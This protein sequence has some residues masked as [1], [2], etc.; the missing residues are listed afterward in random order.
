MGPG[1]KRRWLFAVV[2][3]ALFHLVLVVGFRVLLARAHQ[4]D[5][6]AAPAPSPTAAPMKT[7]EFIRIGLQPRAPATS[8]PGPAPSHRAA[9]RSTGPGD[10]PA[11]PGGEPTADQPSPGGGADSA[12]GPGIGVE[13][14]APAG[15]E[16]VRV[17]AGPSAAVLALVHERLAQ[18]AKRCY[19]PAAQRFRQSGVVTVGFCA[20]ATGGVE[21]IAVDATS[22][23]ALLDQAATSCVVPGANPLPLEAAGA[24]F[25]LPIRFGQE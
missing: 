19:P 17:P 22:G 18:G 5:L 15:V 7:V 4:A 25:R 2:V 9:P 23:S 12:Q 16:P 20:T 24:C 14:A 1:V 11:A 13:E 10:A 21:R 3:S 8:G 6:E